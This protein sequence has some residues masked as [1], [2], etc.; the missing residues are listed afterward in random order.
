MLQCNSSRRSDVI[1]FLPLDLRALSPVAATNCLL[2]GNDTKPLSAQ[3][4]IKYTLVHFDQPPSSIY[5]DECRQL[6]TPLSFSAF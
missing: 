4:L 3:P 5:L 2:P 1:I 6:E